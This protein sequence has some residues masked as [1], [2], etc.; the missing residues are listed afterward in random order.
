MAQ[1]LHYAPPPR[2]PRPR[3]PHPLPAPPAP[4]PTDPNPPRVYN[5]E[6]LP[7]L[8]AFDARND[9]AADRALA[10]LHERL[11]GRRWG[12]KPFVADVASWKTR[13]SVI[14]RKRSDL[15]QHHL[16]GNPRADRVREFIEAKFRHH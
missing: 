15:W 3:P 7:L 5:E 14:N 6:I 16:G 2:P 12:I 10:N 8:T 11:N 9:A 1:P 13:F 4:A